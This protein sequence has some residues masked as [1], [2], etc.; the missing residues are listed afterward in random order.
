MLWF[1]GES[2]RRTILA[3]GC[4]LALPLFVPS[5]PG[6][7][8]LPGFP[9]GGWPGGAWESTPDSRQ[10]HLTNS[11]DLGR[12]QLLDQ[13]GV[14]DWHQQ[15]YRGQGLKIAVLDSGFRGYRS[16]LGKSLPAHVTARSFRTD[17]NLE[18]RDSQHGILCAEVLHTLAPA[19]ELLFANWEADRPD[20]FLEAA[21][22]ARRQGARILSCSLIMPSWSDGEGGG[23]VNEALA[24]IIGSGKSPGDLLC[25]A[26]AGNTAQRHWQGPFH[27]GGRGYHE[28]APGKTENVLT[29][30]GNEEVSVEMCWQPG[31]NYLVLVSDAA[32]GNLVGK[33]PGHLGRRGKR[34]RCCA[35]VRFLPQPGH[36]Y[37]VRVQRL[38]PETGRFHLVVLGGCL[39][40]ATAQGSIAC[41]ADG[42]AVVAVGAVDSAG[43]RVCYSSCGPNSHRPK[44]DFV[45]T[46]PFPSRWRRQPFTGTSAAAPQAAA[47]AALWWSRFPHWDAEQVRTAMQESALDL[48]PA[49]HDF[50]TG[51]GLIRLPRTLPQPARV[52]RASSG[53]P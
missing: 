6:G 1:P 41:P 38:R 48:G 18:A 29:P 28:W 8:S 22:W 3:W 43:Q 24:E 13:L 40:C 15:G 7:L 52:I 53:A 5:H 14:T 44:P 35:V 51:Y 11:P 30:W 46:V 10:A 36:S 47:L 45:A 12:E 37:R 23:P 31:A 26:S 2:W 49:G 32:T 4:L 34:R 16:H 20:Q 27:D 21:R 42:P 25:F 39:A 33:S 50:E 17:G 9:R 19:A